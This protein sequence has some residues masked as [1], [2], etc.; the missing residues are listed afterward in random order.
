MYVSSIVDIEVRVIG[1]RVGKTRGAGGLRSVWLQ[2]PSIGLL[3]R[4][5]SCSVEVMYSAGLC[6]G[7]EQ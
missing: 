6:G 7:V 5:S 4:W 2:W 1:E 3:V